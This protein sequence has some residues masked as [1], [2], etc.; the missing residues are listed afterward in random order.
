MVDIVRDSKLAR[1]AARWLAVG[2]AACAFASVACDGD[3]KGREEPREPVPQSA[4]A[5][6]FS[7]AYCTSI[8]GCCTS[9]GYAVDTAGCK[10]AL[11]AQL[12]AAVRRYAGNPSVVFDDAEAARCI[13]AYREALVACGDPELADSIDTACNRVFRGTVTEG[14]ECR[15]SIDCVEPDGHYAGCEAGV[16]TLYDYGDGQTAPRARMGEAC[17]LTAD[18][19]QVWHGPVAATSDAACRLDDGLYCAD[20]GVCEALPAVGEPCGG[21]YSLC[22]AGARC[23]DARCAPVAATGPCEYDRDCSAT[24]YCDWEARQCSARK[25]NGQTC[26]YD[27]EC[28]GG[29]CEG[30]RCR[31]FSVA[32]PSSCAGLLDD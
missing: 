21:V 14:G 13:E 32:N 4:F 17:G 23:E 3:S 30:D 26:E 22:A 1:L 8:A 19:S 7:D 16:C 2:G 24:A 20:S 27:D 6:E 28:T 5:R 25:A 31:T 18:D 29:Q 11:S 9:G 15:E 10:A 12:D